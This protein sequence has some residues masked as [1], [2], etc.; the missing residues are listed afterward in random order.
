MTVRR[1]ATSRY[2]WPMLIGAAAFAAT[3]ATAND[4][5]ELALELAAVAAALWIL[6][7]SDLGWSVVFALAAMLVSENW[8]VI[9]VPTLHGFS[10]NRWLLTLAVVAA[11][12]RGRDRWHRL[13]GRGRAFVWLASLTTTYAISSAVLAGTLG[14]EPSTSRLLDHFGLVPFA[15]FLIASVSF[16]TPRDR[17][18]LL[19]ALVV[20]GGYLGVTAVAEA[21]NIDFL[22]FP[23]YILDPDYGIHGEILRARGPFVQATSNGVALF[24]CGVAAV[25][26]AAQW[27]SRAARVAAGFVALLASV[28]VFATLSRSVWVGSALAG[29]V[30]LLAARELRRHVV[31]AVLTVAII[32][33]ATLFLVPGLAARAQERK[34]DETSVQNRR[35]LNDAALRMVE[36]RPLFGFGW[37]RFRS[38]MT[39]YLRQRNDYPISLPSA[40]CPAVPTCISH[41]VPLANAVDLGLVG[42]TLWFASLLLAVGGAIVLRGPPELRAWRIGLVAVSVQWLFVINFSPLP[43]AFPHAILW[44]WA[45]V[46]LGAFHLRVSAVR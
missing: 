21:G 45:G 11:V 33:S 17:E 30:A 9:G 38:D 29:V 31:P 18:I 43:S 6:W 25:I 5:F 14:I 28:G 19:R 20:I 3:I 23:R 10:P 15:L 16:A 37:D 8:K 2:V 7:Q 46:T 1:E 4:S 39:L 24:A 36:A 13:T 12:V 35:T 32:V 34:A 42:A 44:T 26:A 41:N 27:R 22:V 40:E